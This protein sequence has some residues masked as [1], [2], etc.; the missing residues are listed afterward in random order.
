MLADTNVVWQVTCMFVVMCILMSIIKMFVAFF[1]FRRV[2]RS[3]PSVKL[4]RFQMLVTLERF[5]LTYFYSST[6]S[7]WQ[8][9]E[10]H[11]DK[12]APVIQKKIASLSGKYA[13]LTAMSGVFSDLTL[14]CQITEKT[15]VIV[16]YFPLRDAIF[17]GSLEQ[18]Y[19]DAFCKLDDATM[20]QYV[21]TS[22]LFN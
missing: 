20:S 3:S 14:L 15:P 18:F 1:D 21:N 8:H 10:S 13:T 9:Q 12:I 19:P 16:A 7:H 5:V 2:W 17:S 11:L 4:S 6:Y 22:C